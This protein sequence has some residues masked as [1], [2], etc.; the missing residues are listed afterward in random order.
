MSAR[1]AARDTADDAQ[2]ADTYTLEHTSGR[3]IADDP[4]LPVVRLA[5]TETARAPD[6]RLLRVHL[7]TSRV[8][9]RTH[10]ISMFYCLDIPLRALHER[11]LLPLPSP[12]QFLCAI[13]ALRRDPETAHAPM[14][15]ACR[16]T[17]S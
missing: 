12:H 4:S 6:V 3:P 10:L 11:G 15:R 16:L 8:I 17:R 5:P 9:Q 13:G 2:V 14:P 1:P 7:M